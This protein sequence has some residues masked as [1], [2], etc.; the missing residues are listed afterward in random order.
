MQKA[1]DYLKPWDTLATSLSRDYPKL[2]HKPAAAGTIVRMTGPLPTELA[3]GDALIAAAKTIGW[4]GKLV[5]FDG[6]VEDLNS[7]MEQVIAS[8]PDIIAES[9]FPI[10]AIQKSV[11]DAKRAGIVVVASDVTDTPTSY[12]GFAGV[13]ASSPTYR[14]EGEVNAYQFMRDSG[15][16]GSVAIFDVPYPILKVGADAFI[17]TVKANCPDCKVSYTVLQAK[18][19][20]TS[21]ATQTIVSK[22]Q[23]AP[24]TN[25]VMF[26]YGD[27]SLGVP[28]ALRQ[29]GLNGI[30]IFG[31]APNQSDIAA[32][33]NGTNAWWVDQA[34]P[35]EGWIDLYVGLRAIET[36]APVLD[37]PNYPLGLMT[38]SNVGTGTNYPVVPANYQ[39]DFEQLWSPG[40]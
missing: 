39:Q 16:K 33:R 2:T 13:F 37:S 29:A 38:P 3:S 17:S 34:P 25:Y 18:D 4:T 27:E 7:K 9:G 26:T 15:C 30:K 35:L 36:K 24:S 40:S 20:G 23:A 19:V 1:T 22:L 32:L 5:Q 10:A 12:P 28:A 8:H 14:T 21:V 31:T 11:A 6:S